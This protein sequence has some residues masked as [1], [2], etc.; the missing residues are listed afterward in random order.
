MSKGNNLNSKSK[1]LRFKSRSNNFKIVFQ[2]AIVK[3]SP[4]DKTLVVFLQIGPQPL[5]ISILPEL[6]TSWM[7]KLNLSA[8][9]EL[10][11]MRNHR[12]LSMRITKSMLMVLYKRAL[13]EIL[14][15][16]T[17]KIRIIPRIEYHSL[18]AV[19]RRPRGLRIW[20]LW[21]HQMLIL[22]IRMSFCPTIEMY[23]HKAAL[24]LNRWIRCGALILI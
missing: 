9:E 24:H 5:K 20:R 12:W 1:F 19:V 6:G 2:W 16:S 23:S 22:W 17:M 18:L 8:T 15:A 7:F 21:A 13:A 3:M 11:T 14:K 10:L 4:L